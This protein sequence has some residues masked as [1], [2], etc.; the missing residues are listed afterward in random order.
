[1]ATKSIAKRAAIQPADAAEVL[2]QSRRRCCLC[3]YFNSDLEPKKGQL[4]HVDR[5]HSKSH[6]NNLAYLCLDHHNEY[7]SKHLQ[8]KNLTPEELLFARARLYR[9]MGEGFE[10]D[11]WAQVTIELKQDFDEFDDKAQEE[12][13]ELIKSV[14]QKNAAIRVLGKRRGSVHLSLELSSSDALKVLRALRDGKLAPVHAVDITLDS[15]QDPLPEDYRK[16]DFSLETQASASVVFD[17]LH[18]ESPH[19]REY[20]C[21]ILGQYIEHAPEHI[22]DIAITKLI[23]AYGREQDDWIRAMICKVLF[24]VERPRATEFLAEVDGETQRRA[25]ANNLRIPK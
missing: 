9:H 11:A 5:D 7:D 3:Y 25:K 2:I 14:L 4:A 15:I 10:P 12:V 6:A 18:R 23:Q 20:G 8:S 21:A 17:L 16:I 19:L 24:V 1:M 22:K 13:I